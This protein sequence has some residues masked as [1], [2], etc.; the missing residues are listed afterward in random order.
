MLVHHA[1]NPT[2]QQDGPPPSASLRDGDILSC[3]EHE[4]YRKSSGRFFI[5]HFLLKIPDREIDI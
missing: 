2:K 5:S 3:P 1:C 4:Y